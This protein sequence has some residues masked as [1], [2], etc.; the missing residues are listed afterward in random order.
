MALKSYAANDVSVIVGTRRLK[1]LAESFVTISRAE[2][3]FTT[4][5]GA[6]GEVTR[7]R[8]SNRSGTIEIVLQQS[9]EDNAYLQNL[10][11]TDERTG[12]GI[13]P[14]K[15]QDQSGSFVCIAAE[16]W[17]QK[18]ADMEFAR[19]AGE[20]TWTIACADMEMLGGGN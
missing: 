19:D 17:I 13:V 1:G 9:S 6:D 15:V 3:S 10:V 5:V 2:D 8:T 16:A 11:N 12:G 14:C 4:Q 18:P 20:R 7:S